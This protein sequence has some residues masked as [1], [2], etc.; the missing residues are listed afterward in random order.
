M[1]GSKHDTEGNIIGHA[2][3]NPILDSLVYDVE[4]A[5]SKF[6]VITANAIARAMYTQCD[7]ERNEYILLDQFIG[8]KCTDA[9]LTLDQQHISVNGTTLQH[10]STKGQVHLLSVEGRLFLLG[11]AV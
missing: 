1:V 3:N 7:P 8:I 11:I 4:F 10:E 9:A 6:T 2:H 5:H